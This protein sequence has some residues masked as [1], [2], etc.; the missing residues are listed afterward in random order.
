MIVVHLSFK[1]YAKAK[2]EKDKKKDP[3]DKKKK[4]GAEIEEEVTDD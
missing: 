4:K 2:K 3:K 1:M